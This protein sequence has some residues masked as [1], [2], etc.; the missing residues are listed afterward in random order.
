MAMIW[1][2]VVVMQLQSKAEAV[3][4]FETGAELEP[5]LGPAQSFRDAGD[6][7]CGR[8]IGFKKETPLVSSMVPLKAPPVQ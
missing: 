7:R 3:V 1:E 6:Q 8:E 4:I 5:Q 2:M